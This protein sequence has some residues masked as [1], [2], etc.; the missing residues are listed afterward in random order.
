MIGSFGK[1]IFEVSDKKVVSLNNQIS[2]SYKAK[3]SEHSPIY[4]IGM[5]RFQ[6]REL[7]T[8]SFNIHFN[9]TLTPNL[10]EEVLKVKDMFEKGEVN[11]LVFGGQVFGENPFIITELN[12]TN[13]YYNINASDFDVIE[14]NLSL[15]EYIEKPKNHNDRIIKQNDNRP[16]LAKL[17]KSSVQKKQRKILKGAKK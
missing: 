15:K 6:G 5:L 13:S 9:R 12:E 16:K 2:R 10:R 3:I 7:I 11:N 17:N 8:V 14:L 4:G 1:L